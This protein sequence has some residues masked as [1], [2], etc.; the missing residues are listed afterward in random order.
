[1]AD[2]L[3]EI[4]GQSGWTSPAT[5][6][7]NTR[8]LTACATARESRCTPLTGRHGMTE[9]CTPHLLHR[10]RYRGSRCSP[11]TGRPPPPPATKRSKHYTHRSALRERNEKPACGSRSTPT[12]GRPPPPPRL[13][14]PLYADNG[15]TTTTRARNKPVQALRR[16]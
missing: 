3:Q 7:A 1:V 11:A 6:T 5:T 15:P 12:T 4:Q 14:L 8:V 10:H 9:S 2:T 13:W 16:S